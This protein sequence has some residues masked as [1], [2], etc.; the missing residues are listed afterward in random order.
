MPSV[1]NS[2]VYSAI[3]TA[4]SPENL[5]W[6]NLLFN[7]GI[8][9]ESVKSKRFEGFHTIILSF[10]QNSEPMNYFQSTNL[11]GNCSEFW[12]IMAKFI[13]SLDQFLTIW[14]EAIFLWI[15]LMEKPI[16]Q[17]YF[18]RYTSK[19]FFKVVVVLKLLWKFVDSND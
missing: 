2:S 1:N 5:A 10:G 16:L 12:L 14:Y 11:V 15:L 18:I 3:I 8:N 9:Q 13:K 7:F 6:K 19:I 4:S 17:K